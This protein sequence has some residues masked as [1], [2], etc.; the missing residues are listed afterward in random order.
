MLIISFSHFSQD[1]IRKI[2][3]MESD[4]KKVA[5]SLTAGR[6]L[7]NSFFGE[8]LHY[9]AVFDKIASVLLFTVQEMKNNISS[10]FTQKAQMSMFFTYKIQLF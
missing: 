9:R 8:N 10:F 7:Y 5:R 4:S 6:R 1:R 3:L 2:A